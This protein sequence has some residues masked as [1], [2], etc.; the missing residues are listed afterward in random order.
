MKRALKIFVL[1]G[2]VTLLLGLCVFHLGPFGIRP[3]DDIVLGS[4]PLTNG[5]RLFVVAHRTHDL[6][7]AYEVTLYRVERSGEIFTYWMGY[8]E[9]Y[10]WACSIRPVD[11][12]SVL[13]IRADGAVAALYTVP[14]HSLTFPDD[15]YHYGVQT[16]RIADSN[17]VPSVVAWKRG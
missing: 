11:D 14:D 7:E 6:V 10:W 9:S 17:A 4:A 12:F 3:G 5:G 15:H 8:E 2:V 1:I 13:Q 16:G